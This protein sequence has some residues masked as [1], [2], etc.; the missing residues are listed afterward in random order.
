[1]FDALTN[2][3]T[4]VF[5]KLG[6]KGH[7]GEKDVDEALREVRMALL[8]ADVN[9][10]VARD[11]VARVR[12]KTVGS[13][14]MQGLNP[15]QHVVKTVNEELTAV[16][17]GGE[18]RMRP[19]PR[20]PTVVM[21]VGLQGS[22]KTTTAAKLA[23][24]LRRAPG[25][26]QP[27]LVAADLRRPAA[28]DQLVALGKQLDIPVYSEATTSTALKVSQNGVEKARQLGS[29]WVLVDTGGRLHIDDELM[30]ELRAIKEAVSP[31][32]LLLVVDAMTGQDA[33]QAAGEFHKQLG[34]TG[35]ILTKLDGDAR[36][37]AALSIT[38]VTGVP[39]KFIGTGEKADA[40]EAFY[41][42]RM[43]SRILGMGD[44]LTLVERVEQVIDEKKALE[45]EKKLR[46]ASLD[47]NDMLEQLRAVRKMG[48][49]ANVLDMVPGFGAIKKRLPGGDV[50]ESRLKRVEAIILSMT[51][52]ERK[53]PDVLNGSRRKRIAAGSG[54]TVQDVNQLL[55]QFREIQKM[56][57][58]M[59][60]MQGKGRMPDLSKMLPR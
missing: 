32:E 8:E 10:R 25:N 7:L 28:V 43:A 39:I 22:G 9:F 37:G 57:K 42:D 14:L 34:L 6:G 4:A 15:A 46:H 54:T 5:Q 56:M 1:M 33:V 18:H 41:P 38:A 21:L 44:V 12:E 55:N 52:R 47:L 24:S 17:S 30:A 35:L 59:S 53:D 45:L 2:K 50:D 40:L 20:P 49:I 23:L 51:A 26:P 27:L 58:Q 36:G 31:H 16:L 19:S 3:L 60:K 29:P 48:S 11:L 13:P